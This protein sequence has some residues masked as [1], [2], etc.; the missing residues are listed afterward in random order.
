MRLLRSAVIAVLVIA[1]GTE[2][3]RALEFLAEQITRIGE[4]THRASLYYKDDRWRLE[5]N[6]R[7]PVGVTI[8]RKDKHL[9]WFLLSR[10]KHFK[11][12]PYDPRQAPKVSEHMD[13]EVAREVIGTETREGHP[14][15]LYEVTVREEGRLVVYYQW[16]ATDL[17]LPL[18]L[19]RKD[20]TWTVEFR[21]VKLRALP[22]QLFQ[23]PLTYL[24]LDEDRSQEPADAD[25]LGNTHPPSSLQAQENAAPGDQEPASKADLSFQPL[26]PPAQ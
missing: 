2:P 26:L 10:M 4:Q 22:D 9:M 12:L 19:T 18:R 21:N 5:H 3:A 13:G 16:V 15:T 8:V 1:A 11:T 17:R 23:I 14:T 6:D 25:V 20:G 24:P 7:G